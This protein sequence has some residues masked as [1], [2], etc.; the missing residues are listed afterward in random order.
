MRKIYLGDLP[1]TGR[2]IDWCNCYGRQVE[3][4]YD[5]VKGFITLFDYTA[6]NQTIDVKYLNEDIY[7]IKTSS[8]KQCQLAYLIK[9]L[10]NDFYYNVG[11][12]VKDKKR[13]LI[14]TKCLKGKSRRYEYKCLKCGFDCG[15]HYRSGIYHKSMSISELN[16]N[17]GYGCPCCHGRATVVNINSIVADKNTHWMI[18]FFQGGYDEA[19]KYNQNSGVKISP[20]CPHCNNIINKRVAIN[21][22]NT[23]K[24]VRCTCGD[25][26]SYGEKFLNS[27]L[28][29]IGIKFTSQ[30]SK[31]KFKWCGSYKFDFYF[32]YN[33][34]KY[35]VEVNGMQHY[36][37]G[38][39]RCGGKDLR[40]E[41]ERDKVKKELALSNGIDHY[42]ELDCRYSNL[43][44]IKN[45]I[46]NSKL[47]EVLNLDSV[48]YFKCEEF[49]LGNLVKE[50]CCYWKINEG[51]VSTTNVS[52]VFNIDRSTSVKYLKKGA[53]LGWCNYDV[54]AEIEKGRKKLNRNG[55]MVEIFKEGVSCGVFESMSEIERYGKELLGEEFN[56]SNISAVC[57]GKR[58]SHKGYTFKYIEDNNEEITEM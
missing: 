22:I 17:N 36:T 48:D 5:D 31:T 26:I 11:D 20:I 50:V 32:Q 27:L 56:H 47:N 35:I 13:H 45:S 29:Q 19:K 6:E 12:I 30:L 10:N 40:V 53:K 42:I 39:E 15:E 55:K 1:R 18:P 28:N 37:G 54:Q 3:F 34:H 51:L 4:V 8:L 57:L 23:Y 43:E 9:K 14:I 52:K 21:S 16:L 25:K 33:K 2:G 38:F 46:I 58:K 44:Y 49:A 41:Q 7:N 24:G